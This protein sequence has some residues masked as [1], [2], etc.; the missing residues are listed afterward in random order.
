MR[1]LSCAQSVKSMILYVSDSLKF[2][3]VTESV[4]KGIDSH[5]RLMTGAMRTEPNP[6][7]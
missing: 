6:M 4:K 5:F 3:S 1:L 2:D 7:E